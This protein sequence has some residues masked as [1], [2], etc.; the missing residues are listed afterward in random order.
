MKGD[1][2]PVG[3]GAYEW[4][5]WRR[6][7]IV[8]LLLCS[9]FLYGWAWISVDVLRPFLRASLS[10]TLLQ[11]GSLYSGQ[12]AGAL[13]GAI[14]MGQLADRFGRRNVLILL[15]AGYGTML[16]MGTAVA[17]YPE[18]IAQRFA[19]GLFMGGIFP[20]GV[21]IYVTLFHPRVRGRL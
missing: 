4:P 16:L 12:G 17:S 20:V 1:A 13:C 10:L 8:A 7:V 3:H 18:L 21:G 9:E 11:A 14:L 2:T 5:L 6:V 15:V 19:L